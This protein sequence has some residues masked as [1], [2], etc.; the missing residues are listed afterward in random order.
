MNIEKN[1]R[2][3][4]REKMQTDTFR[5]FQS[6]FGFF[7]KYLCSNLKAIGSWVFALYLSMLSLV[8]QNSFY[9]YFFPFSQFMIFKVKLLFQ[10]PVPFAENV[11]EMHQTVNDS[12]MRKTSPHYGRK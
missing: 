12:I 1:G 3:R 11:K 10:R 5:S 8:G 9:V 7:S 4:K 6:T 2:R